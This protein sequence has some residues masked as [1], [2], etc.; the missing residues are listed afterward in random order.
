M[1][2]FEQQSPFVHCQDLL[3]VNFFSDIAQFDLIYFNDSSY[4]I[5]VGHS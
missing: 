3:P 4:I 1:N 2:K 5:T